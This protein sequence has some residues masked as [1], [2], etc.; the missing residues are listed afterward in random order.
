MTTSEAINDAATRQAGPGRAGRT[1]NVVLWVLQVLLAAAFLMA[2]AGKLG[3]T[4][5]MVDLF[6]DVGAGQ[7][8]RY[9]TGSL[10]LAGA[11]GLLVPRLAGL[12]ALGLVGVMVGAVVTDL[13]VLEGNPLPAL[14]LLV[15]AAVI[16]LGRRERTLALIG[17]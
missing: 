1:G 12:A 4:A 6:D 15:V 16:A 17:R 9:L 3:G 13:F 2:A 7:W 14:S 5:Q 8:L 11:I 10:E